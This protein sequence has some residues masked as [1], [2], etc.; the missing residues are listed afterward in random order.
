MEI[1][2][3]YVR[4]SEEKY[5]FH[6]VIQKLMRSEQTFSPEGGEE[7]G[8]GKE[9][10]HFQE[11]GSDLSTFDGTGAGLEK[12][13]R[14]LPDDLPEGYLKTV[15]NRFKSY[16]LEDYVNPRVLTKMQEEANKITRMGSEELGV[17]IDSPNFQMVLNFML[18]LSAMRPEQ[19]SGRSKETREH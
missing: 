16:T 9:H 6:A 19:I 11:M 14:S 7:K 4:D 1:N 10:S 17:D 5:T 13:I 12:G 2:S 8:K 18:E 3:L 15:V